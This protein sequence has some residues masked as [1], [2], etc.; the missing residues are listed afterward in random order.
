LANIQKAET[1]KPPLKLLK[2]NI[3]NIDIFVLANELNSII[4]DGFIQNIYELPSDG[5]ILI[6]FRTKVGKK[7]VIIDPK[8]RINITQFDYPVPPYP[9]QFIMALRKYM[10]GRRIERVYQYNLDR[11]IVFQL[12]SSEGEPWKFVIEFFSGGNYILVDGEDR[13]YMAKKYKKMRE[14]TILAKKPYDFPSSRGIDLWNLKL[15]ILSDLIKENNDEVVRI[16][17]RKLSIGGYISEEICLRAKID[18]KKKTQDLS[19]EEILLLFNTIINFT[20]SLQNLEISPRI[21]LN[22]DKK[23]IGFEPI[24]LEIYNNYNYTNKETFNETI[25]DFFSKFDNDN[26]FS[27]DVQESKG[28]LTKNEKILQKQL[29]K[30]TESEEKR[31]KSLNKGHLI[32]QYLNQIDN[33][34]S[35]IMIQKREKNRTWKEITEILMMGK[36]K[37]IPESLIFEKIF[38]KEVKVQINLESNI[39]K[40]DLKKSA[41]VNAELIYKQAKKAKKK[42]VGATIAAEVSKKKIEKQLEQHQLIEERKAVLLK[43]PKSKWYEKFRWFI[44]SQEFLIVGG[45]DASSNELIVKKHMKKQDL[46]FH[47]DVRGS[48]VC[49]IQNPDNVEIPQETINETAIFASSYS[50]AWKS[51]WGSVDIFYV[52]PDQVSK[53]PKSGEYLSKGSFYITGKKNYLSKPFLELGIGVDLIAAYD[54]TQSE[55]ELEE[56]PDEIIGKNVNK[57]DGEKIQYYPQIISAPVSVLKKNKINHV[58]IKPSKSALKTSALAKKILARF[59]KQASVEEK[60]WVRLASINDIIRTTPSGSG[61]LL[62]K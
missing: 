2:K 5:I 22:G 21:I 44:S 33:L 7:N 54:E 45:R 42:I 17:A 46:F 6:K 57:D 16:L 26:L 31:E 50:S 51:G 18:K 14:R 15:E 52:N 41:I 4:Q 55:K 49:I 13:T 40:L 56:D 25:D 1:E 10:K 37:N 29:E 38:A 39:F 11:I 27:G 3:S 48:S 20:Q 28:K 36:E 60:M 58:R 8:K 59:I 62:E 23:E 30:I 24:G 32:Y 53:S 9:S 61:E 34:I 12:R 19:D 43:K 47:T 35:T